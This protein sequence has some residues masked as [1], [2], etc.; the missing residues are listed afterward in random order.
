MPDAASRGTIIYV[1]DVLMR[2]ETWS[3]HLNEMDHVLTLLGTAGAKLAIM[4]G[5]WC[6]TKVNYVGLLVGAEGILPQSNRIQAVRNIKTPTNLHEVRSFLGVC[7]YSRQFI[8]N[9]ADLS[10]PLTHLLQKDTPFIW[11]VTHNEAVAS[12]KN[13][14][15]KAPCLVYPNKDKTFFLEV[16]FSEQ[17]RKAKHCHSA[18]LYQKYDQDKRVVAYASKTLNPA[19]HKYSDCEKALLST[20]WAIKHFTS[21][22]GG[23]KVIIETCHQPVTFLKNQRIREGAVHNS[24]IAAWLMTLQSHDVVINYA[25]AKNLPLGSAL[26]VCQ[27]C[28]DDETDSAPPPRDIAPPLPS[29]HHYFEEN[30]CLEMPMAFVDGCSYRHLD[31]LQAGVGLVWHND[32]PCKP[33][34]F[35]LGNKTSQFAEVAGVLITLQTAVKHELSE[36]AICTDSNYARLTFL[37]HLPFWKQKHMTTSS[38]KEVKNKELI[39]ACDDLITKHDIQVYWKKVKGHSKS[40]GRDKLGNDHADSMAKSGAIHGTPWVFDARDKKNTE[41]AM[42]SAVTRSHVAP[43]KTSSHEH[44]VLLTHSFLNDDL[45]AMQHQDESLA[46]LMAFLSDP[47]NHPVSELALAGSHDLRSLYAT[48]QHLTLVDDLLVYVSE[49]DTARRWVVPKTQRGIMIAHAHDEPCG[50]HRGVKATCETL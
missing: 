34:Q 37:C 11:E 43:G 16:G 2:S 21:Y 46:T 42:V 40:P 30:V 38:G 45:V 12:L 27:R 19:E 6:R 29:N 32:I 44:N 22:V 48:K 8:E 35:Q 3:H 20:V 4:K 7:N 15:C 47:V 26:A 24:R 36:L 17:L 28:G 41:D 10:K 5:Q 13:Q 9:Y 18:G 1:D 25:K 31:H 50:G 49:T 14:L 33:L 39:L 23:Q